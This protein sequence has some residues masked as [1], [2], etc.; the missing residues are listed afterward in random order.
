MIWS[1]KASCV[2]R[3]PAGWGSDRERAG[4]AGDRG[5][6]TGELLEP[7][8]GVGGWSSPFSFSFFSTL[9]LVL[10]L[11]DNIPVKSELQTSNKSFLAHVYPQCY[12]G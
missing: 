9:A 10:R 4:E 3:A 2:Q 6:E 5:L 11:A 8:A 1:T 12:M 7:R